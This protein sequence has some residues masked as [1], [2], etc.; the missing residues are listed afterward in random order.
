LSSIRVKLSKIR[1]PEVCPVC[2]DEVEDLV[3]VT[4]VERARDDFEA[5]EWSDGRDK[6]K[7][8]LN[9]AS[10]AT[11][12]SVPTCM[13]HGSKSVRSLRTKLVAVL[14]FFIMFYPI[15]FYALQ[16][17]LALTYSRDLVPPITGFLITLIGLLLFL[18]YGF[19]PRALERAVRFHNVNRA[20]DSV[21]LSI[22]TR[23]YRDQFLNLNEMHS[24]EFQD[25]TVGSK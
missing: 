9:A 13:R 10:G 7:A 24:D 5:R 12:F 22:S 11:T 8:A 1:F 23:E 17:N 14:G 15:L 2:L 3:F 16:I 6:T 19:Y 18:A 25:D 20:K 21:F 4:I